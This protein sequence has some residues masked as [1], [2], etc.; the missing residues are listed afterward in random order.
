MGKGQST[1]RPVANQP[2]A[3]NAAKPAGTGEPAGGPKRRGGAAMLVLL[4]DPWLVRIHKGRG[5]RW[6]LLGTAV[7][8]GVKLCGQPLTDE[9]ARRRRSVP[10]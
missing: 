2:I 7:P 8:V 10:T 1:N 6:T 4:W 9:T 3:P 5:A